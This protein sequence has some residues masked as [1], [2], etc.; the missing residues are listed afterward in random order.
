MTQ[1][2]KLIVW[3]MTFSGFLLSCNWLHRVPW[4]DLLLVF[5]IPVAP[6]KSSSVLCQKQNYR[7]KCFFSSSFYCRFLGHWVPR[8]STAGRLRRPHNV[9]T[10]LRTATPWWTNTHTHMYPPEKTHLIGK[11]SYQHYPNTHLIKILTHTRPPTPTPFPIQTHPPTITRP[12]N[13]FKNK[14]AEVIIP[15]YGLI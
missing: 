5:C 3:S 14:I 1:L 6:K 10:S 9:F 15:D 11:K 13:A 8:P 2:E 12:L 7:S 4:L